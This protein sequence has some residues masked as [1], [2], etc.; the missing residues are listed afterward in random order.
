MSSPT[1][2][3]FGVTGTR[4]IIKKILGWQRI[5]RE[6]GLAG[7]KCHLLE[8]AADRVTQ[9]ITGTNGLVHKPYQWIYLYTRHVLP[10]DDYSISHLCGDGRC[11]NVK[12]LIIELKRI[13]VHER[14]KCHK[15]IRKWLD[16]QR[17][18]HNAVS[19]NSQYKVSDCTG[20]VHVCK[21]KDHP[22]FVSV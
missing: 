17:A 4:E 6:K 2:L 9:Y 8:S 14:Q 22:C 15:K 13:N 3:R 5:A 19:R 11:I 10:K 20:I 12:H 16:Q 1:V 18:Q 7:S 21:H